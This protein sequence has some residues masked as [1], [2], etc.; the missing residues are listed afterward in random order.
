MFNS[1]INNN[2]RNARIG[3]VSVLG[4]FELSAQNKERPEGYSELAAAMLAV[5]HINEKMLL[6][7]YTLELL[8]N[9]TKVSFA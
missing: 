2:Y 3:K 4:L 1:T 9:D 8:T 6:P 7:G 5:K